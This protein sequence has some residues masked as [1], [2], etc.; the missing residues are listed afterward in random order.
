MAPC[1]RLCPTDA[2]TFATAGGASIAYDDTAFTI[3]LS[4]SYAGSTVSLAGST[5][6]PIAC[7]NA[8][9][10]YTC[11]VGANT[12]D[13]R[14]FTATATALGQDSSTIDL[15]QAAGEWQLHAADACLVQLN[16]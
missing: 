9:G 5:G 12:G 16:K 15:I 14:S 11:T 2:P 13:E 8:D 4:A 3:T 1:F 7:T 10:T 6:A